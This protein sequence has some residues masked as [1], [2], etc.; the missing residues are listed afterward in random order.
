MKS[1]LKPAIYGAWDI[2]TLR[3]GVQR[4][5]C[6]QPIRFP[7]RWS[8]WYASNYEPHTFSF[9]RA[10]CR[11]GATVMDIGAHFGLFSV[12][13]ARCVGPA[14]RVYAF[15]PTPLSRRVLQRTVRLN[16]CPQIEIRPEAVTA[17][18]GMANFY[19]TGD[20]AS[21][22]NSVVQTQRSR[23]ATSISTVSLDAFAAA[24]GLTVS[25]LKVDVEGAEFQLLQGA[26][27]TILAHRPAI[28][29]SLHPA[30]LRAAGI[31]LADLWR[32]LREYRLS[33]K[34]LEDYQSPPLL[35]TDLDEAAF[36]S[37]QGLFDVCLMPDELS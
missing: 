15:E 26:R 6:G 27:D 29:L 9:L 7:P 11:P 17:T 32:L 31:A 19:D 14:G 23:R 18:N 37:Q 1:L 36:S 3:R 35:G 33:V 21:N 13:M 30:A 28:A 16:G 8:R 2:C 34:M 20:V 24:R 4:T 5:I 22:A 12:F 10:H 25:C